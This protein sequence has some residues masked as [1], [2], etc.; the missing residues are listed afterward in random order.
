MDTV[1][2]LESFYHEIYYISFI[3]ISPASI[4]MAEFSKVVDPNLLDL[5]L[6]L[7]AC[8]CA[9]FQ[10]LQSCGQDVDGNEARRCRNRFVSIEVI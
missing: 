7:P 2:G 8:H 4:T 6:C 5:D 9:L 3:K 1:N 10:H